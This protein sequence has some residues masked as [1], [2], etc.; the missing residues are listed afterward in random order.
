MICLGPASGSVRLEE[1]EKRR[2]FGLTKHMRSY[3]CYRYKYQYLGELLRQPR[4]STREQ[5]VDKTSKEIRVEPCEYMSRA[6][7]LY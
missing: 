4:C 6:E 5:P 7:L 1:K 3:S 2:R